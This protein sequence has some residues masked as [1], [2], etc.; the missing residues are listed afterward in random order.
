MI[1]GKVVAILSG[2]G[3]ADGRRRIEIKLTEGDPMYKTLRIPEGVINTT[4]ALELDDEIVLDTL[5]PA[6]PEELWGA[7]ITK[8]IVDGKDVEFGVQ[9]NPEVRKESLKTIK[10][11]AAK[12]RTLAPGR[13]ES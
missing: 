8:D 6:A 3:Y 7:R 11:A 5:A 1:H 4:Q 12:A 10:S 13:H 2:T 9:I